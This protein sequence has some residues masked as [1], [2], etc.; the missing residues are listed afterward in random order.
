MSTQVKP[1]EFRFLDELRQALGIEKPVR[2]ITLKVELGDCVV[3]DVQHFVST[4]DADR[5]VEVLR[6]YR[7][8]V[9]GPP[10]DEAPPP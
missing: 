3:A 10:A 8:P 4:E 1:A 9:S 2:A 5:I 7:V 6:R